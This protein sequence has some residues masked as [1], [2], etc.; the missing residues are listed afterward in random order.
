[1]LGFREVFESLLKDGGREGEKG[2]AEEHG[3]SLRICPKGSQMWDE[4]WYYS[5][6]ILWVLLF[7]GF[8]FKKKL[9]PEEVKK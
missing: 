1:M 8:P 2:E 4:V 3:G 7:D 5:P 6:G 9:H